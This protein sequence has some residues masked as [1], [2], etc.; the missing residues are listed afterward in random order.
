MIIFMKK[1]INWGILGPGVIASSF[2]KGLS[3]LGDAKLVA[4]GSRSLDRAKAFAKEFS[5]PKAYGSYEELVNDPEIDV[6][7]VAS[8]HSEHFE[9]TM[10]CLNHGKSV[11]CE[12]SITVNESQVKQLVSTAR[13]KNLFLMEAMWTRFFPA[14]VKVRKWLSEGLIGE[15]RMLK[16]DFC[17][18]GEWNPQGRLLN[19]ELAGGALL[20]VGIYPVSYAS[21]VFGAQPE[22]I[23][24]IAYIGQTGVDEQFAAL[25]GYEGGKIAS[26]S[27]AIRTQSKYDAYIYGTEGYI[28]VPE[29]FMARSAELIIYGREPVNYEPEFTGNGYNYEAAEVGKLLRDGATES[30]VMRLDESVAIMHTMDV[31]RSRW[32]LKYPLE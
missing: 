26:I 13:Q 9:H 4:V 7:Y 3:V 6:I 17:F 27:G 8:P 31:I 24:T 1:F 30:G 22:N 21:M 25:F 2:A 20:D 18:C 28:H 10:L 32:G 19:L 11:L 16:A 12:K 5:I 23:S 29:F 14:N 15:V